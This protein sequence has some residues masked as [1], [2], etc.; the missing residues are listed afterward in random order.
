MERTVFNLQKVRMGLHGA[1]SL[2]RTQTWTYTFDFVSANLTITGKNLQYL[3]SSI[4]NSRREIR[5]QI[6]LLSSR[7][8]LAQPYVRVALKF[9]PKSFYRFWFYFPI[10]SLSTRMVLRQSSLKKILPKFFNNSTEDSG[11]AQSQRNIEKYLPTKN[12]GYSSLEISTEESGID[13]SNF[14]LCIVQS[15]TRSIPS[16]ACLRLLE[17]L[18]IIEIRP[19]IDT[20]DEFHLS[21]L[22]AFSF[23]ML[24]FYLQTINI[25]MYVMQQFYRVCAEDE[26]W[27]WNSLSVS[28]SFELWFKAAM[29]LPR[30]ISWNGKTSLKCIQIG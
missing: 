1:F 10:R 13:I 17:S 15:T 16:F 30:R 26:T 20:K 8:G 23:I 6:Q 3:P 27:T 14:F 9:Y 2:W 12:S 22:V 18:W 5:E 28:F 21:V 7:W 29:F 25:F 19:T 11:V 24:L 4:L